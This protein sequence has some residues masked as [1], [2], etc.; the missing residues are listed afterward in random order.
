VQPS[1]TG[2]GAT[3]APAVQVTVQDAGGNTVTGATNAITL[4]IGTNP[5][6]GTLSGTT[7]VAAVNGVAT[8]SN[9]SIDRAGAGYTLTASSAGLTGA[10]STPFNITAGTPTKLAFTVQP[11][12]TAAT[13]AISPAVQVTIQDALGNTVNSS[14]NVT[15][16]IGTNPSG[17]TLSGTT[18]VAAVNGIATFNNLSIDKLGAGYTLTA[19]SAGLTG[20]TSTPFNIT[21]GAA[22]HL[23][24]TVQPSNT[25]AASAITPAVQVTFLDAGN[26]VVTNASASVT[27]AI[28]T[29]PGGGTLSGTTTQAPVN[30]VATF[31]NLSIDKVGTGYSLTAN[32]AGLPQAT[33]TTFDIT[34]GTATKLAF[35]QQPTST[36]AG[37]A[38]SPAVTVAI[39]DAG[40]NTVTS[41]SN[42]V[43]LAIG[44]NPSGGTL[45][46]TATVAAVS[47][48]A[49][50]NNLSINTAGTA[51]RCKRRPEA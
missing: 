14:A 18:T 34:L 12:N 51:T 33:S 32:A 10:T 37:V 6:G 49:T 21:A 30:G 31:N 17:G 29:N 13:Q 22:T 38:I 42:N 40:G 7:T 19:A 44:T 9:L 25:S 39:Q 2:A 36:V 47:G 5:A 35:I 46:G 4:T 28:G 20:A 16:A 8:F 15:V 50:F 43:T 27:L 45:S 26:N 24:F 48:I 23:S 41:A 11:S 3:I 1:N